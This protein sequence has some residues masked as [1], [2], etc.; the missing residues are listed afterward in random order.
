LY[1]EHPEDLSPQ[2]D[3]LH[4]EDQS[5]QWVQNCQWDQHFQLSLKDR[6]RQ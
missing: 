3:Q 1:L 2:S 4:L 6:P 5:L